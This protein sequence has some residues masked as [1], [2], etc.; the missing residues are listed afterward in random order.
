[1]NILGR[2]KVSVKTKPSRHIKILSVLFTLALYP[3]FSKIHAQ[4]R[5][6]KEELKRAEK[7]DERK[8]FDTYHV[9]EKCLNAQQRYELNMYYWEVHVYVPHES[10]N[11]YWLLAAARNGNVCAQINVAY[12]YQAGRILK[13]I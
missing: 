5:K 3:A 10:A 11:N 13:K 1:M 12:S 6:V 8:K 4:P 9:L 2:N 7:Y